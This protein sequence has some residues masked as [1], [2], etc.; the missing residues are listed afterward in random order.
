MYKIFDSNSTVFYTLI[1]VAIRVCMHK[2]REFRMSAATLGEMF[3]YSKRK[4]VSAVLEHLRRN[5]CDEKT[6][7]HMCLMVDRSITMYLK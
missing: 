5:L 4:P 3:T 2:F 7:E 6:K 1:S